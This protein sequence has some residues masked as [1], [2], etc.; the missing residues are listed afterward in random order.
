MSLDY[1]LADGEWDN[2][3]FKVLANNDTGAARGHQ[4]GFVVP[5]GLRRYFP[6]LS[7]TRAAAEVTVDRF[8]RAAL[9]VNGES[10]G[11][12]VT[13]YQYQTW[14]GKKSPESRITGNLAL[15]LGR[16]TGGDI[17]VIQRSLHELD[18]FRFWLFTRDSPE[19]DLIFREIHEKTGEQKWGVLGAEAPLSQEDLE[20]AAKVIQSSEEREFALFDSFAAVASSRKE[21][22]ARAAAFRVRVMN[23]YGSLCAVCGHAFKTPHGKS[24]IEAAHIAP[25]GLRGVDDARNGLALC[26]SHH[27]AFDQGLFGIGEHRTVLVSKRILAMAENSRLGPLVG[28]RI[29]EAN[30][31]RFRPA[32]V[33][34]E[35]H[36]NNVLL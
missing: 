28:T 15:I 26:R 18:N 1:L 19:F 2:P 10:A 16:A 34:L 27:W 22:L 30:P 29:R 3:F 21:R 36:R 14:G 24:E 25:R 13:R 20:S 11:T 4:G 32:D 8:V 17:L 9:F 7:F 35:W 5:I 6:K 33:A 31:F 12:V 23:A